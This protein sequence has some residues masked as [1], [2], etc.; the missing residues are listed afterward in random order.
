MADTKATTVHLEDV[1]NV[2]S[3]TSKPSLF[4][5]KSVLSVPL[6]EA[7]VKQNPKVFTWATF[8]LYSYMMVSMMV[9]V[10]PWNVVNGSDPYIGR[11][12]MATMDL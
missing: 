1:Q 8:R 6:Q 3:S 5:T 12:Q 2:Q 10:I 7:I 4:A 9:Y 11:G